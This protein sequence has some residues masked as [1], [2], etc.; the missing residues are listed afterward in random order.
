[1]Q[2]II[3]EYD[4]V[5]SKQNRQFTIR[6]S[7]RRKE[8]DRWVKHGPNTVYTASDLP[9]ITDGVIDRA[10]FKTA[11]ES[12]MTFRKLE[13]RFFSPAEEFTLLRISLKDLDEFIFRSKERQLLCDKQGNPL[14]FDMQSGIDLVIRAEGIPGN[15]D[16]RFRMKAYLQDIEFS[17]LD[18]PIRSKHVA[19]VLKYR[20]VAVHPDIPFSF[21]KSLPLNSEI[22]AGTFDGIK[23]TLSEYGSRIQLRIQGEEVNKVLSDSDCQPLLEIHRSFKHADLSFI[24]PGNVTVES[25]ETKDVIFDFQRGIELHRNIDREQDHID[26]LKEAGALYRRSDK[27]D[28]FL[29]AAN[30]DGLLERLAKNRYH[31]QVDNKPLK[32]DNGHTWQISTR[33]HRLHLSVKFT[34]KGGAAVSGA[35]FAAFNRRR[36]HF[37][38]SDGSCGFIS[39]GLMD[40][41]GKLARR[42][43]L[44]GNE[45]RFDDFDFPVV[46]SL[47][48]STNHMETDPAF[49]RLLDMGKEANLLQPYPV[50]EPLEKTLRPYQKEGFYWLANLNRS[51]FGGILADDMGLGKTLMVLALLLQLKGEQPSGPSL[52]VVPKSLIHNWEIEIK[53]F[54]PSLKYALH[55]GGDRVKNP[56]HF[57]EPD[58]I[59]T[60]YGLIRVDM[61]LF[62]RIRLNYLILDEAQTIKN[63][64]AKITRAVKQLT[65]RRRLSISG[66]PVENA[67]LD[68]WSHFDFLM[69]GMLGTVEEFKERYHPEHRKALREL[70][71]RTRPFVLRRLKSQVCRELPEKTEITLY[72]PFTDEQ[73]TIY[74]LALD[75]SK[76]EISERGGEEV[77]LSIHLLTVLLR[78]RQIACDPALVMK[79]HTE[80]STASPVSGKHEMVMDMGE[81]I[82]SQGHKILVFS[83]FVRHLK[84]IKEGFDRRSIS[85]FYLDGS[86]TDRKEEIHRFQTREGPCVFL[87]SLK[88]GGLGLNLTEA[89]YAFLLDPWWNPAV[90][91]QAIDRCHRIGQENPVT[92]YRFITKDSIEEKVMALQQSK[93]DIQDTVIGESDI[94]DAH[95]SQEKLEQLLF[96]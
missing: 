86:T 11:L 50:P 63:P 78:L 16:D 60:S 20:I 17:R 64:R 83:Q 49:K 79:D 72:C 38:L 84:R 52:L 33:N 95:L 59:I 62:K 47:L 1:M 8:G 37:T 75:T 14:D 40:E 61:D 48:E 76:S 3:F 85:S 70:S 2:G 18:Y 66:T 6:L 73:K 28:W 82:L 67:P 10:L 77:S 13:G 88:A 55:T 29:P 90:E 43:T 41:I 96:R 23:Q 15:T 22:S 44:E 30:L 80:T 53:R 81:T 27:G 69:P 58:L 21:F 57:G 93:K 42:G 35:L 25:G 12:E 71:L 87:I 9:E 45:I 32:M 36:R 26:G 68:L 4:P 91:N 31:L 94:E 89:N 46:S 34:N 56:E 7:D 54:T 19:G 65:S 92:V 39:S 51:G 24:Y 5:R 74:D